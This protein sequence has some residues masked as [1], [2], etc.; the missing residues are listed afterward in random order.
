MI[1]HYVNAYAKIQY[2]IIIHCVARTNFIRSFVLPGT[3]GLGT[4]FVQSL[5][6]FAQSA[7]EAK[8]ATHSVGE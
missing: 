5:E 2:A 3:V 1:K 8:G 6:I 4:Q 7:M